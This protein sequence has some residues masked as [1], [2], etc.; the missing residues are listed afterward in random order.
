MNT[1]RMKDAPNDR[2]W[3]VKYQHR[4]LGLL[5]LLSIITYIDRVCIGVA[6]PRM[7][8]ALH[9]SPQA[10]GWV[11]SVFFLSYS[12]FEIPSGSLGDR[13]GP[14]RVLTRIVLWWSAFTSLTGAVTNYTLLLVVRFCFGIGEAGAYP[15]AAAVIG[16]WIPA[17]NRTRAWGIVWMTGQ[18]GAAISPLLV[19]PIQGRY[20]WRASFFVF[21]VLG[22]VWAIVWYLWFR[23][24]PT[25]KPGV[26]PAELREIGPPMPLRHG[27]FPWRLALSQ[28]TFW[29]FAIVGASYVYSFGFYQFWLQTYLVRG[30]GYTEAGLALSS[31]T[32]VT[33]AC[34]NGAGG[35]V[36]D[37][38]IR[39]FGLTKGRRT[40]G[41]L[42]LGVAGIFMVATTQTTS[43]GWALIFLTV[44]YAGILFQQP[45]LCAVSLDIGREHAGIVF[46]FMNT[47]SNAASALSSI[48]F[49]Y[50]VAFTGS[51]NA[52]LVPMAVALF[53]GSWLWL[54]LD[55]TQQLFA[56]EKVL[57]A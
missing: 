6:G 33:G 40:V 35:I 30:H 17:L 1:S 16:R 54:R 39:R 27:G 36:G 9:I 18:I 3:Q 43:G 46:G 5:S 47:A 12:V 2:G 20:G 56:E 32:Y 34:A 10:W 4:V 31:L 29:K 37:W 38:L 21:G 50:I 22:V 14:R 45:N 19:V 41:A 7:Q 49:G 26:T 55:P 51:Y 42:G 25:E 48:A 11:A 8:D 52:P 23:D 57:V 44:A 15:N 28:P 24:L 53:M 13:I